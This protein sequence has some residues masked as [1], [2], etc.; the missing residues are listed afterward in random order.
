M[1]VQM[2]QYI[3]Y[4]FLLDYKLAEKALEA[5]YSEDEIENIFDKYN[6]SAFTK[7]LVEI[8]GCS[9]IS[10]GMNSKYMFFGKLFKKSDNYEPLD[11]TAMP[12]VGAKIK[13]SVRE[14]FLNL[15]GTDLNVQPS[16]VLFTLYR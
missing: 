9:L 10:D 2:N 13:K 4:G 8:D 11:T 14:K 3:G 5:K 6:D 12:K 16:V 7:E 15:F 1:S